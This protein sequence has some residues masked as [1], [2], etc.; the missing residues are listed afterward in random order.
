MAVLAT[1]VKLK[2]NI[3]NE[4]IERVQLL[5]KRRGE[6]K[7]AF[8][9]TVGIN[10]S[11]FNRKMNGGLPFTAKDFMKI[12]ETLNINPEWISDG[13]GEEPTN[14]STQN[15]RVI[16]EGMPACTDV[17]FKPFYDI[18]FVLGFN[19]MYNDEANVPSRYI[20]IPGY[21]KADFWCRT[22]GDSMKPFI[23]NG[24][25]V[26]LKEIADWQI[27]LPMNEVYAVMTTNDMRTIKVVRK[28]C[29]DM[30]LI[31]HAYNEEYE[32]QEI[33]KEAISKVYQ[34]LGTIKAL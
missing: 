8:A 27:F 5:M 11:N 25:I 13:V 7:N 3:M 23:S 33:S 19:N 20:S 12:G 21:E 4:V 17:S 15:T 28:G 2:L 6:T 30:H 14:L 1:F 22:S 31:L 29:D 26:A 32:D 18:D 10:P 16:E 24:D 9:I 34:V